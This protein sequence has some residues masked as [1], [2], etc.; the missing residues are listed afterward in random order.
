MASKEFCSELFTEPSEYEETPLRDRK[1]KLYN[2][3]HYEEKAEFIRDVIAMANTARKW[4]K[5]AYLLFGLDDNG[6]IHDITNDLKPYLGSKPLPITEEEIRS[7]MEGVR[8]KIG[9]VIFQYITPSPK[10]ELEWGKINGLLVAYLRIEPQ[11]T[12]KAFHVAKNLQIAGKPP[13]Y[14]LY[15]GQS[16]IRQGESKFAIERREIDINFPGG[17]EVPIIPPSGWLGYFENL[18]QNREISQATSKI[19]YYIDLY[20]TRREPLKTV[21][22]EFLRNDEAILVIKGSPGSGKSTFLRR[23][24]AEWADAGIEAMQGIRRR[25]EFKP[26]PGWIPVYFQLRCTRIENLAKEIL[27]EVNSIGHFWE[28]E[29]SAPEKLLEDPALHWLICFDGLDELWEKSKVNNFLKALKALR[30]RYPRLKILLSTRPVFSI[31]DISNMRVV[32]IAPLS[33]GQIKQY[34][35][36]FINESNEPI[37]QQLEIGF[38]NPEADLYPLKDICSTP[39]Y[40]EGLVSII[41]PSASIA[42]TYLETFTLDEARQ[43]SAPTAFSGGG[44]PKPLPIEE[45]QML[46]GDSPI[47]GSVEA[48][49]AIAHNEEKG[50]QEED[51]P[52]LTLGWVLARILGIVWEREMARRSIERIKSDRWWRATG[53]LSL[54]IDGHRPFAKENKARKYYSSQEGLTW[55]LNLGILR[56]TKEGICFSHL[57][58]QHYFGAEYLRIDPESISKWNRRCTPEFWQAVEKMLNEIS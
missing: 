24:V 45:F 44:I 20:T 13:R 31:P 48:G 30:R 10:L 22:E 25:E 58:V 4:R 6:E 27:R 49:D 18:R 29:P 28:Q 34:L 39:L 33:E 2:L 43:F 15:E 11:C 36:T 41:N 35:Q 57:P 7:A 55:V 52:P 38:S 47:E 5:P 32:E 54:W 51:F 53:K 21:V 16:W 42:E 37:Y 56:S 23:I 40:L 3:S 9:E 1:R 50:Q 46:E 12:A 19:P 8:H 26:P 17:S 14:L